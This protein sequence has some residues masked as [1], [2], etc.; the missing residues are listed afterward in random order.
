MLPSDVASLPAPN[1][2]P[3]QELASALVNS[4]HGSIFVATADGS[5]D[6][7]GESLAVVSEGTGVAASEAAGGWLGFAMSGARADGLA[8][9]VQPVT[10]S[11]ATANPA[12]A[13][14]ATAR[15]R[16]MA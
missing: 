14:G 16:I 2:T 11:A 7:D 1:L 4:S 8:P 15:K 12:A 6:S 13:R 5:A 10:T 9:P 3:T